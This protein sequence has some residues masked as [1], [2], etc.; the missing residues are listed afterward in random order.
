MV[1]KIQK[2]IE[3]VRSTRSGLNSMSLKTALDI[4]AILEKKYQTVG[5]TVVN[6]LADMHA[7]IEMRPDM[8]FM[9][10]KYV[11]A[12]SGTSTIYGNK[13][14]I[15]DELEKHGIS[16]TGSG[17]EAQEFARDKGRAKDQIL[18]SGIKT[19]AFHIIGRKETIIASDITLRYPIFIKPPNRGGGVGIDDASFAYDFEALLRKVNEL[20]NKQGSDSLLEEYL[21]GREFTVAIIGN[22][23]SDKMLVMPLELV[24]EKNVQGNRILG[25]KEKTS[26]NEKVL[27]ITNKILKCAVS[28][29]ALSAFHA[30][31]ASNYGRIDIRLD[32]S[33]V[34]HFI[35]ANLL[36][37]LGGGYFERASRMNEGLDYETIVLRIADIAFEQ[38]ATRANNSFA[39]IHINPLEPTLA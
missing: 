11:P 36:P 33:G 2:H 27:L 39:P 15:T 31:G 24:S 8:V 5:V 25:E 30:L 16:Y 32:A 20:A 37:G 3:I 35:E 29:L 26:D 28:N 34:P 1:K 7:L 17:H 22:I 19:S 9:G 14:W 10:L 6:C 23:H 12:R 4:Q 13:V 18:I 21:P 38:G